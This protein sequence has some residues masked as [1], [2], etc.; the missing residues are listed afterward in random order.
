M[1]HMLKLKKRLDKDN[2]DKLTAL[3]NDALCFFV[4]EYVELCNP[5]KV[6]VRSNSDEDISYIRN[7]SLAYGE[8]SALSTLGHTI[9]FDSYFDQARDKK[10]T[11]YLVYDNQRHIKYINSVEKADGEI[12][13][14]DHL[15]NIMEGKEMFVCFFS[16]GPVNSEF[17]ILAVQITDSA[18]VAHSEDILYRPGYQAFKSNRVSNFFKFVHSAGELVDAVSKNIDKRRVYID[19]AGNLVYSVNTQYAGNTVGLKKLA[20][21]LA[22]QK[23]SEE[24]WLAEHMFVMGV[25][26]K[27][28]V[29]AYFCGAYPSMCGKTSTAMVSG[30]TIIGDDIAYLRRRND[31]VFAVNVE[32]GIFGIVKDVNGKDD[33]LIYNALTKEGELIFSNILVDKKNNPYWLGKDGPVPDGGINYFGHWFPGKTDE[34]GVEITPSHKNARFTLRLSALNNVD[35]ALDASTGVS[36]KGIIYGGRDSDTSCPVEEALSWEHGVVLKGACLESETT[37]ATLGQ[38]GVR[39]FNP[40]S[41]MDF[42]AIPLGKYI[43]RHLDFGKGLKQTNIYSVN[44]FLKNSNGQFLNGKDD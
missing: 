14:R 37:A 3:D 32:R 27:S 11:K 25:T 6:F 16:L 38:E 39:V 35:E 22:I 5:E 21:R 13:I 18:Y 34:N 29:K 26:N 23:A 31:D 44:Y 9:H 2:F 8:E 7:K 17:S 41:N 19:L 10:N 4:S 28:G 33:P 42:L 24:N 1:D 15:K 36:V 43:Q 12:E 30:E 20:L 40:M